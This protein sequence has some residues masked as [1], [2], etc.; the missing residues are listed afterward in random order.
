MPRCFANRRLLLEHRDHY[1][2]VSQLI[3]VVR[4]M[5]FRL[6]RAVS[7]RTRAG[8]GVG[9]GASQ[10]LFALD[11]APRRYTGVLPPLY[12]CCAR[13]TAAIWR[14]PYQGATQLDGDARPRHWFD[15]QHGSLPGEDGHGELQPPQLRSLVAALVAGGATRTRGGMGT[16]RSV[17]T[18]W[19]RRFWASSLSIAIAVSRRRCPLAGAT[20]VAHRVDTARSPRSRAGRSGGPTGLRPHGSGQSSGLG[21]RRPPT[22]CGRSSTGRWSSTTMCGRRGVPHAVFSITFAEL[23]PYRRRTADVAFP[24]LDG[25]HAVHD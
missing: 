4:P 8:R 25:R 11:S 17:T 20:S 23:L 5:P 21:A 12:A 2:G 6:T 18:R 3:A 22:R 16:A 13:A 1:P 7:D 14:V 15:E 10:A 9:P 19:P 24:R